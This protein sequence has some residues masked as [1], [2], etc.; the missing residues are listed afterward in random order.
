M[1]PKRLQTWIYLFTVITVLC[2][3]FTSYFKACFCVAVILGFA[4]K[5]DYLINLEKSWPFQELCLKPIS[6]NYQGKHKEDWRIVAAANRHKESGLI[7]V[8]ARH[9]D[10]LMRAQIFA[11]SGTNMAD[12]ADWEN[13]KDTVIS[14]KTWLGCDQGFIDNYGDFLTRKEAW[15][16]ADNAGQIFNQDKYGREGYL[17]SENIH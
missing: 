15:Y 13:N 5:R 9:Y 17:F 6:L 7:V 4:I 2:I 12:A 1:T 16:V 3:I 14:D 10:R 11:I 8:G